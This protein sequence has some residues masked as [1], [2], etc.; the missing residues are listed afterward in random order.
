MVFRFLILVDIFVNFVF[1]ILYH[2]AKIHIFYDIK[3][4]P[5]LEGIDSLKMMMWCIDD[6]LTTYVIDKSV[7]S[8]LELLLFI[9]A[10]ILSFSG[11]VMSRLSEEISFRQ[12]S[13][14]LQCR[15]V[16]LPLWLSQSSHILLHRESHTPRTGISSRSRG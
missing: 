5:I 4:E 8:S 12:I 14:F 13:Y 6:A 9:R 16:C 7:K 2:D 11:I 10:H 1:S 15:V 3:N